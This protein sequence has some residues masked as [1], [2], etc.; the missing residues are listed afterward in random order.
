MFRKLDDGIDIRGWQ[1]TSFAGPIGTHE[2]L[3]EYVT[4]LIAHFWRWEAST[5]LPTL[6]EMIFG[7]NHLSFSHTASGFS[8]SL[9]TLDALKM[10]GNKLPDIEVAAAKVWKEGYERKVVE[11]WHWQELGSSY[12]IT[13]R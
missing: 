6:P 2:E 13:K 12:R 4:Q 9:N 11:V 8:L 5:G 3:A 10:V 1:I 7:Q